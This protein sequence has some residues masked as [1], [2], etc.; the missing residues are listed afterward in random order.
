LIALRSEACAARTASR[1]ANA[2]SAICSLRRPQ[3][4]IEAPVG[5]QL[6]LT[7]PGGRP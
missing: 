7:A 4:A 5:P 2:G 3:I 6:G 1:S